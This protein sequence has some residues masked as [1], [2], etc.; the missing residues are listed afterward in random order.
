MKWKVVARPQAQDDLLKASDWYE[1]KCQGLG[2]KFTKAVMEVFDSLQINPLMNCKQHP[3]KNI[4]CRLTRTFRY[5]VV[6]EVVPDAQLV[7][8]AAV[9]H[10]A[11]SRRVWLDRFSVN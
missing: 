5:R 2:T 10:V 7:I 9:L 11:R 1:S 4:R 8:V 3:T 6:Y